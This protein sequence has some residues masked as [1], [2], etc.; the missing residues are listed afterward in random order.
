MAFDIMGFHNT[1]FPKL[2][3]YGLMDSLFSEGGNGW[4]AASRGQWLNGWRSVI[5]GVPQGFVLGIVLFNVFVHDTDKRSS[6]LL[7][8]SQMTS[9]RVTFLGTGCHLEGIGQAQEVTP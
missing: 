5:S 3:R 1:L 6:A 9:S 8:N 2:R 4:M 7:G